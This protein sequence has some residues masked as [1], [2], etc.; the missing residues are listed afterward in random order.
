MVLWGRRRGK[1]TLTGASWGSCTFCPFPGSGGVGQTGC[2]VLGLPGSPPSPPTS[3]PVHPWGGNLVHAWQA[4]SSLLCG[5]GGHVDGGLLALGKRTEGSSWPSCFLRAPGVF[6]SCCSGRHSPAFSRSPLPTVSSQPSLPPFAASRA[7]QQTPGGSTKTNGNQQAV[8]VDGRRSV[9]PLPGCSAA[10]R[11]ASRER[12]RQRRGVRTVAG[13]A[14]PQPGAASARSAQSGPHAG[15]KVA[16]VPSRLTL[17]THRWRF[18]PSRVHAALLS[19]ICKGGTSGGGVSA[20]FSGRRG[21]HTL[22][23]PMRGPPSFH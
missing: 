18:W 16:L 22:L 17:G 1:L 7:A 6:M 3:W 5:A 4:S 12:A 11:A 10:L 20:A 15:R 13:A 21:R 19:F 2:T 23:G 9:W 8:S 14:F